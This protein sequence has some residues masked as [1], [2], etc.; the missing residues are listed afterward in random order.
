MTV[1]V[2][3]VRMDESLPGGVKGGGQGEGYLGLL[4][5]CVNAVVAGCLDGAVQMSGF[6]GGVVVAVEGSTGD[7]VV[8]PDE[9]VIKRA[10]SVHAFV[11]GRDGECLVMESEG[12]FD[13]EEWEG[14][15]KVARRVV[16]GVDG[17]G[18]S[19]DEDSDV[20]MDPGKSE[21]GESVLAIM[22]RAVEAKVEQE[23][24]WRES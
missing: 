5:G 10:R 1:Q 18:N 6:A 20:D 24:R 14:V 15:E 19:N 23:G 17:E 9:R 22:R 2:M 4:V 21:M 7:L 12:V 8:W 11:Y 13:L 16:V 3:D